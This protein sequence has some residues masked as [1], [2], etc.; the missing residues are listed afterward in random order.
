MH[1]RG[2]AFNADASAPGILELL[3]PVRERGGVVLELGCGSGAL[4]SHLVATGHRVIATDA[5]PAMLALAEEAVPDAEELRRLTL[6]DDPLPACDAVVSL[7]HVLSY[8]PDEGAIEKGLVAAADALR[9]E[10]VLALDLLDFRYG[11][12]LA[13]ETTVGRVGDDWAIV[14]RLSRPEKGLYVREITTFVLAKDGSWRRDD[15]RHQNV[16][17]DTSRLP[18]LLAEHGVEARI[19]DSFGQEDLPEGLVAV[20]GSRP[21]PPCR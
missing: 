19:L 3:E 2:Y 1:H 18:G 10:G 6:P 5:S 13:G 15:E 11:D 9:P 17:V 16:L 20:V 12:V 7:G 4:T 21:D 14:T 8:L